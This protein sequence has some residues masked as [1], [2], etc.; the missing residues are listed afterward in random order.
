VTPAT[1]FTTL[2]R[3]PSPVAEVGSKSWFRRNVIDAV[4]SKLGYGA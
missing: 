3:V 1:S 2:S 4:K